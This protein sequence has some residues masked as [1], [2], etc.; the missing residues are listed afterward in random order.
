VS[1][2]ADAEAA[3]YAEVAWE[4]LP[5]LCLLSREECIAYLAPLTALALRAYADQET[6]SLFED[7]PE[8]IYGYPPTDMNPH[9]FNPD[10]ECCTP[11]EIAAWNAARERWDADA[12]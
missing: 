10:H 11:A 2:R 12:D 6:V 1:D 9:D 3:K 7:G 5:I 4:R 8:N